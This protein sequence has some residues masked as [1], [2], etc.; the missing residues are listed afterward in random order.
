MNIILLT[1]IS[2]SGKSTWAKNFLATHPDYVCINRDALR[3]SL[4]KN[5]DGYYQR[6]DLNK[7]EAIVN[8]LSQEVL[9]T[10]YA[11][12][13]NVLIDNTNLTEKYINGFINHY[14]CTKWQWKLFDVHPAI[15]KSRVIYRDFKSEYDSS[16]M[17]PFMPKVA[18]I[19]K[20]YEQF[21]NI[22]KHLLDNYL[23]NQYV[24]AN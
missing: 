4:V 3:L 18:Y 16:E 24:E 1:G 22:K 19:D 14:G 9:A 17:E 15:A 11:I 21:T 13:Y 2:G 6:K 12:G 10:A 8:N 5:L 23:N 20:Q 7:L